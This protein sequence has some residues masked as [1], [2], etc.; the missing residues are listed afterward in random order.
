MYFTYII[1][2]YMYKP[3]DQGV[4]LENKKKV[5]VEFS[6][7]PRHLKDGTIWSFLSFLGVYC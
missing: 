7:T 2:Y 3:E 6:S 4:T 1:L 5:K